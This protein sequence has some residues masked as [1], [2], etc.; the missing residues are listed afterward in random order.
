MDKRR[1]LIFTIAMSVALLA[2]TL[3][4]TAS[5]S[6]PTVVIG[7]TLVYYGGHTFVRWGGVDVKIEDGSVMTTT[8]DS[9]GVYQFSGVVTGTYTLTGDVEIDCQCYHGIRP[10]VEVS[11]DLVD[12]KNIL[13]FPTG[14]CCYTYT[15]LPVILKNS[16]G[17][18]IPPIRP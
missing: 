9:G 7:R 8:S 18:P 15:F 4:V 6:D 17:A 14:G 1:F 10:G 16:P 12:S 11:G 3:A 13:L 2:W 5:D